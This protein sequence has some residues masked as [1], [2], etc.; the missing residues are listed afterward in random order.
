V[1]RFLPPEKGISLRLPD[2]SGKKHGEEDFKDW[3]VERIKKL[4]KSC[5]IIREEE[6]E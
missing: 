1:K 4:G 2:E 6:D 5:G 3:F